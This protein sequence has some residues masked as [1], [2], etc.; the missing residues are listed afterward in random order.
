MRR[1]HAV[2]AV[3]YKNAAVNRVTVGIEIVQDSGLTLVPAYPDAQ[4]ESVGTLCAWLTSSFGL[5]ASDITTHRQIITDGS[6][7][8]PRKFPCDGEN[9]FW[10][11]F[12]EDHG[13]S[14]NF[15]ASLVGPTA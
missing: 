8:D 11:C 5:S 3:G 10:H 14:E 7:S 6:R 1:H 4:V 15:L 2:L 13:K 12:W 9:G